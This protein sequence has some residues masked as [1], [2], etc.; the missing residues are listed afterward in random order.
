MKNT[1][2]IEYSKQL[3]NMMVYKQTICIW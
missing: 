1:V 2:I 3:A